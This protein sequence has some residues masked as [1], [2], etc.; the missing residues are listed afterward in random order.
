[1][2]IVASEGLRR[3]AAAAAMVGAISLVFVC[4]LCIEILAGNVSPQKLKCP[5]VH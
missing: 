1:M 3:A 5:A 4:E 2:G